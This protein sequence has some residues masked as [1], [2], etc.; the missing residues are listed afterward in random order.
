MTVMVSKGQ[1]VNRRQTLLRTVLVWAMVP[2]TV[3]SCSPRTLCRCAIRGQQC[4]C[5]TTQGEH[6]CCSDSGSSESPAQSSPPLKS[7]GCRGSGSV[8][9]AFTSRRTV[10]CH[11]TPVVVPSEAA[12][13][14]KIATTPE[15]DVVFDSCLGKKI[16]GTPRPSEF[17][18]GVTPA[19]SE[20]SRDRVIL[21]ERML[22]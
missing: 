21:L 3:L 1:R 12:P 5:T 4:G 14:T 18:M 6:S 10:E 7:K 13:A 16:C 17:T 22:A 8:P 15:L 19:R 9:I 11:C 2:L 20:I